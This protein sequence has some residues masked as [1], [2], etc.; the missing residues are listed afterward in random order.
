MYGKEG[1]ESGNGCMG[2]R[3]MNQGMGVWVNVFE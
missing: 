2:R 1:Y 3:D